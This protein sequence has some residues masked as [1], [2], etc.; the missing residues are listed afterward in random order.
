MSDDKI[1]IWIEEASTAETRRMV[2]ELIRA[3][4]YSDPNHRAA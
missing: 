3:G 1:T 2:D 4:R